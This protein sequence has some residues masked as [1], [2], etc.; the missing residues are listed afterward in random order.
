M[1]H[2]ILQ[3]RDRPGATLQG[4]QHSLYIY[5]IKAIL[6]I[7][8]KVNTRR[9][10]VTHHEIL[11][12][13]LIQGTVYRSH[14]TA[15]QG[16][17]L[18]VLLHTGHGIVCQRLHDFHILHP[19]TGNLGGGTCRYTLDHSDRQAPFI[20]TRQFQRTDNRHILFRLGIT[21]YVVY[22]P[23]RIR[24]RGADP[25][26]IK[27]HIATVRKIQD[28]FSFQEEGA[29]LIVK[30]L[31]SRKVHYGGVQLH[32]S[33]IRI[34]RHI[35]RIIREGEL[36]VQAHV[37]SPAMPFLIRAAVY[38]GFLPVFTHY[39]R[40]E[41]DAARLGNR[42][43]A[44]HVSERK[45]MSVILQGDHAPILHLVIPTDDTAY[46]Q[47]PNAILRSLV[48][49]QL[50]ERDTQLGGPTGIRPVDIRSSFPNGVPAKVDVQ[51]I[52]YDQIR[53]ISS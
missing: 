20:R 51:L 50:A 40:Q 16:I 4:T 23:W 52:R 49:T 14:H 10:S 6:E 26:G 13:R 1:R 11:Q 29:F 41:L 39:I 22:T 21:A 47:A 3:S 43:H 33:V 5:I 24:G 17:P 46:M 19:V 27:H 2:A 18:P 8:G 32:L 48:I 30:R 7:L 9:E 12:I 31:V 35:Q 45:D 15:Q 25:T 42:V 44:A 34:D 28:M 53:L 38:P 36:S 37:S